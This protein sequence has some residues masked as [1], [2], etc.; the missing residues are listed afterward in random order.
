MKF[1]S[2]EAVCELTDKALEIISESLNYGS[3]SERIDTALRFTQL[4]ALGAFDQRI[5]KLETWHS[6]ITEKDKKKES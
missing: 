2:N 1:D 5:K 6:Q 4:I 3:P